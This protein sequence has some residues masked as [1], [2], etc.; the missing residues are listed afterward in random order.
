MNDLAIAHSSIESRLH[1]LVPDVRCAGCCLKIERELSGLPD[2]SDVNVS[3][4]EKRL[5]FT[6]A[7]PAGA[8]SALTRLTALGYQAAPEKKRGELDMY[9]DQRRVLMAR[10]GVAGIGMMQV[11]MFALTSYLAGTEGIQPEYEALMR[12]AAFVVS[13][14]V[15]LYSAM[16]FHQGAWRDIRNRT[17]GMDVPVSIAVISAFS[18]SAVHTVLG[19]GEVYFDSACMFTFFLLTGRYLE[20]AARQNFHV[21]QLLGDHLLPELARTLSGQLKPLAELQAGD[22]LLIEKGEVIPADCIVTKGTTTADESAFTGESGPALKKI[23]SA[24]LAGTI[25]LD[26]EV[27]GR[28]SASKSDWVISHLSELYRSAASFRPSFAILADRVARY[29]VGVVLVLAASSGFFWWYQGADN[30]FAIALAV[31]V[32]SCPC[33]LSLATPIAYAI[34]TGASRKMGLLISSGEF[35][36]K[37]GRTS[38]VVFDKTGTLTEGSLKLKQMDSLSM[39]LSRQQLIDIGASLETSS[40]HPV[41]VTLRELSGELHEIS[42]PLVEP[43]FGVSGVIDGD[44]YRLGNPVFV[45]EGETPP[46]NDEG[47]W[48]LL[49][50]NGKLLAWFCFTDR[51]RAEAGT[52]IER[53]KQMVGSVL[54]YSGDSSGNGRSMLNALGIDSPSMSMTPDEKISS[55]RALQ[56]SGETVLMIGDG[57]N[58]AGAMAVADIS[59]AVNPVDTLVQSAADATLVNGDLGSVPEVLCYAGKVRAVIKQNLF[60]AFSYNLLVIPLAVLGFVPPWLA[61]LGMSLSSLIVTLNACRLSRTG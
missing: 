55:V 9:Q 13:L 29:F 50:G 24:L 22:V 58:D 61:A 14:P 51:P 7:S 40:L 25:N 8:E 54:V 17:A 21:E 30:F 2:V 43:G 3:Y 6:S 19:S 33:A 38:T 5:S 45:L 35:L 48:V 56:A 12:W 46:S 42:E 36:E 47:N 41:A 15:V 16:P 39:T 26:G 28:V 10:L 44:T 31:L 32:V 18:L 20:L 57:L 59:L 34:A 27:E 53:L 49:S 23:G 1:F 4:A 60:W 11:M 52:T 37:L